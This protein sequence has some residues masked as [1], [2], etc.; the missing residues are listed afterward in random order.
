MEHSTFSDLGDAVAF[1]EKMQRQHKTQYMVDSMCPDCAIYGDNEPPISVHQGSWN[2]CINCGKDVEGT[3]W[4]HPFDGRSWKTRELWP[5][6]DIIDGLYCYLHN[7]QH[8]GKNDA[9]V[10]PTPPNRHDRITSHPLTIANAVQSLAA[11]GDT[12]QAHDPDGVPRT[13]ASDAVMTELGHQD[14]YADEVVQY[15]KDKKR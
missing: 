12:P 5:L 4:S 14:I 8:N 10:L 11:M 9:Y 7:L 15:I 3:A 2:S 6:D 13:K 1:A